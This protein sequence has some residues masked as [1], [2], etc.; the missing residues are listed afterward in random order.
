VYER[1]ESAG[2]KYREIRPKAAMQ[3]A[4]TSGTARADA[5][6]LIA[7]QIEKHCDS[8]CRANAIDVE[9]AQHSHLAPAMIERL[10]LIRKKSQRW[11]RAF[12]TLP[13]SPNR[14]GRSWTHM[15]GPMD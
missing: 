11:R 14:S 6:W 7:S 2:G 12:T 15:F 4:A 3:L 1:L 5:L 9:Q 13:I 8:I 10:K